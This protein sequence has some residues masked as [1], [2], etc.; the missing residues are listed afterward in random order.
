M[1]L[2]KIFTL[3]LAAVLATSS[4][5][6]FAETTENTVFE[7]EEVEI[8][9]IEEFTARTGIKIEILEGAAAEEYISKKASVYTAN[10]KTLGFRSSIPT[11][12]MDLTGT[13]AEGTATIP[14]G[15]ALYSN[16]RMRFQYVNDIG[17][18][19]SPGE[20]DPE[21]GTV[22]GILEVKTSSDSSLVGYQWSLSIEST[23]VMKITGDV[24]AYDLTTILYLKNT[25]DDERIIDVCVSGE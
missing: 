15:K 3:V 25:S 13:Y 18:T 4:I 6:A 24:S 7:N 23:M 10:A 9:S 5:S 12:T 19:L 17:I 16:K 21:T 2:R 11:S 14:S 22:K 20:N 1:K 8:L